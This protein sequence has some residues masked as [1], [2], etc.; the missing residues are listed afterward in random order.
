MRRIIN[1]TY[2]S[3]DGVI[4]DPQDWPSNGIA[5]D[6]TGTKVQ[7]DLLF[8][9]DAVLMGR[10]TYDG[11][12]PV[13]MGRSGDPYSDRINSM[14]KYVVSSSLSDPEWANTTVIADDVV[15]RIREL[16]DQPGQDI[17]QYGFGPVTF[18]LLENGLLDE[19]RLWVHP[20]FVGTAKE[21]DLLFRPTVPAQFELVDTVALNTGIVI[22]SYRRQS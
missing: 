10:H 5:G 11:F 16:K 13:W 7:T 22:L 15:A 3:L 21:S 1:S 19:L 2:I 18:A 12:A 14:A 20:L 8:A 9:C 4:Q 17:V 6:G